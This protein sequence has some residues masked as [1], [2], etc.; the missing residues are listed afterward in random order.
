M[1]SYNLPTPQKK[2]HN[3]KRVYCQ[4]ILIFIA[5]CG[6]IKYGTHSGIE[7]ECGKTFANYTP[8]ELLSLLSDTSRTFKVIPNQDCFDAIIAYLE[9]DLHAHRIHTFSDNYY[10]SYSMGKSIYKLMFCFG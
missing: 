8:C 5:S 3:M 1:L 9:S 4:I 7:K 6:S 10:P 2:Q